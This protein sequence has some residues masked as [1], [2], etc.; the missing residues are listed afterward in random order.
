[1]SSST[2]RTTTN[3][4]PASASDSTTRSA[5]NG[6]RVLVTGGAGAI[7]SILVEALLARGDEVAVL[8][9]FHDFYPR[10][11]KERNL[12]R[13]RG[14]RGFAGV[15]EG[16][17]RD[18]GVRGQDLR[19]L[20]ASRRGA[21]GG[22][23]R[24]PPE[25]RGPGDL[26]GREPAGDL[27]GAERR[28][29]QR[30]RT[31]RVRLLLERVRRA[32]ARRVH[33]GPRGRPPA[34]ALRRHQ[35]RRRA[36]LLRGAGER[37]DG[38]HLP[39]LLQ[40]LRAAHAPGPGDPQ[41]RRAHA[42]RATDSGVRRRQLRA[43]FHVRRGHRRRHRAGARPGARLR[44]LQRRPRQ[45]GDG[46]RDHRSPRARAGRSRAAPDA[47][48]AARRHPAHLGFDRARARPSWATRPRST[49]TRASRASSAG[50]ASP[51]DARDSASRAGGAPVHGWRALAFGAARAH[52]R[53]LGADALRPRPPAHPA[54]HRARAGY[55]VGDRR[56]P[57]AAGVP[58]RDRDPAVR[59]G[60]RDLAALG[61]GP[62][63]FVRGLR[64]GRAGDGDRDRAVGAR[65]GRSR[66]RCGGSRSDEHLGDRNRLRRPRDRR[67]LRGVRDPR[68]LR[69]QGRRQDRA[70]RGRRDP[71]LRAGPR[72]DRAPQHAV[73]PALVHHRRRARGAGLAGDLHRG[74]DAALR[75]TAAPTCPTST[76]SRARSASTSTATRSSS[77]RAPCP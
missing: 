75:P 76:R 29:P 67:V 59:G 18:I 77:P 34:G 5:S 4:T 38:R 52:G 56:A 40:R 2:A 49:S 71:D 21:P 70:A 60:R 22:A 33:R 32:P 68:D 13:A 3:T 39:A 44:G 48:R 47:A 37:P 66:S 57:R 74:A 16:D 53:P 65:C 31:L 45:A 51:P 30:S 62:R 24:R 9:S 7:G 61:S 72:R 54:V 28:D 11:Q 46:E 14:E 19:E 43:R 42:G 55:S 10:A 36:A 58:G 25:P 1:M 15:F 17:I 6:G 26:H 69:R 41:V 50:C 8:D 23:R 73:G 63:G 35:A 12:A 64:P 20:R 27:G